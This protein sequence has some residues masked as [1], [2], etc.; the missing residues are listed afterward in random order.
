M[1]HLKYED[2][3]FIDPFRIRD[4]YETASFYVSNSRIINYEKSCIDNN[5]SIY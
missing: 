3:I 1:N 4:K 2:L 5:R